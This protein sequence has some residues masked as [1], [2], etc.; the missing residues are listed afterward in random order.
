ML[1]VMPRRIRKHARIVALS[2]YA[3]GFWDVELRQG[4]SKGRGFR[5]HLALQHVH[6][7]LRSSSMLT[8][9]EWANDV[10][11][12]VSMLLLLLPSPISQINLDPMCR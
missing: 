12:L 7:L 10:V 2:S 1:Y 8:L 4:R 3:A 9:M 6:G 11:I 5:A